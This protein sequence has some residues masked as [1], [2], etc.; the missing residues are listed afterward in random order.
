M[1]LL[2]LSLRKFCRTKKWE[3]GLLCLFIFTSHSLCAQP[4]KLDSILL[5][6]DKTSDIDKYDALIDLILVY[7]EDNK[8]SESLQIINYANGIALKL[9]DTAKIVKAARITGQLLVRL[10]RIKE[11][12]VILLKTLAIAER[13]DLVNEHVRILNSLANAYTY[14]A[15]YDKALLLNLTCITMLE[16]EGDLRRLS[17][18]LSNVGLTYYKMK[19]YYK[20]LDFYDRA[21]ALKK[22]I[23]DQYFQDELLINM[24]LC[25]NYLQMFS[26]AHEYFVKGLNQC[27]SNCDDYAHING[28]FGLGVSR[29]GMGHFTE[30]LIH[31]KRSY[32]IA[33]KMQD[34]RFQAENLLYMARV[35]IKNNEG[36]LAIIT[37]DKCEA[38][39][40]KYGYPEVLINVYEDFYHF[41]M[42]TK[43]YEKVSYYQNRYISL[44]DSIY[45][46]ALTINLMRIE[47]E[48]LERENNARIASQNQMLVLKEDVIGRQN[49]LNIL[50]SCIAIGLVILA[51][52]LFRSNKQRKVMNQI[53]D[54][55]VSERTKSL[56][57]NRNELLK[58][59]EER[60]L[61]LE[62]AAQNIRSALAT[63]NG[64]CGIGMKDMS[65]P[66]AR[67]YL[68]EV[69][70]T[71]NSLFRNLNALQAQDKKW[72]E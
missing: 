31:F 59:C 33:K 69:S 18:S 64:I 40:F 12:E 25:Y 17:I 13:N 9:G 53:L 19:H 7:S 47:A 23:N 4:D 55:K 36:N 24:G 52:I 41:F 27:N 71:S 70:A 28:E 30:A 68:Q 45:N 35:H 32:L 34:Q 62:K 29:Y 14:Q 15:K 49:M 60:D 51:I 58:A 22:K 11:A 61:L 3:C 63:I 6:I 65:D 66:A 43:N 20:A 72:F 10:S 46:E 16:N 5:V 2:V 8:N 56:E 1:G 57:L 21:L 50:I 54:L 37:M 42:E 67:K 38:I 26:K 48:Y 39:A 44:R